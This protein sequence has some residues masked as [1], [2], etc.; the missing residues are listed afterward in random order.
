METRMKNNEATISCTPCQPLC[1]KCGESIQM[2]MGTAKIRIIVM[3]L[4]RF[5]NFARRLEGLWSA[6][7]APPL[8]SL[9]TSEDG[10][11]ARGA[12]QEQMDSPHQ[13]LRPTC[14]QDDGP[15]TRLAAFT[16]TVHIPS[17]ESH[18]G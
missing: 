10:V 16:F 1:G 8:R 9:C 18:S 12:C 3:E 2:R 4:G 5:T 6:H 14:F 11:W 15:T 17:C 7:H 13:S